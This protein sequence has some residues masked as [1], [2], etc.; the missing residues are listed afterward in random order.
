MNEFE[1]CT[2][3]TNLLF[4]FWK[5]GASTFQFVH[6]TLDK[7]R[8]LPHFFR[9]FLDKFILP[10]VQVDIEHPTISLVSTRS[11]VLMSM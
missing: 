1:C 4:N 10:L 11:S 6:K 2:H 5:V 7:D 8:V 3:I 9:K